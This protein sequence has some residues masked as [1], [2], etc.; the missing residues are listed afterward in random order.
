MPDVSNFLLQALC[1]VGCVALFFACLIGAIRQP[2]RQSVLV[3]IAAIILVAVTSVWA[4]MSGLFYFVSAATYEMHLRVTTVIAPSTVLAEVIVY[5]S[6]SMISL[7][8]HKS[9]SPEDSSARIGRS[10]TGRLLGDNSVPL[11][12][13]Y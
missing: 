2:S 3:L 4:V 5:L 9:S 13:Q 7:V 1:A 11:R 10:L 6:F 12:Y 8:L